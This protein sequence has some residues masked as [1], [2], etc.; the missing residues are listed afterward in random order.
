MTEQRAS[1]KTVATNRAL[2]I[3]GS[4]GI[5][6][7]LVALLEEE[8]WDIASPGSKDLNLIDETAIQNWCQNESG[9]FGLVIILAGKLAPDEWQYK[10][11]RDYLEAYALHAAGPVVLLA[12]LQKRRLIEWWTKVVL[13]SS[14]GAVNTGAVDLAYGCAKAALE[15]AHKAL[16][17]YASWRCYLVRLDLVD[18]RMLRQLPVDTL[19]GRLVMSPQEA[20]ELIL[21]E[22]S[23]L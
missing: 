7:T 10:G 23:I 16:S 5:G 14:V 9:A 4:G 6:T 20:A 2:V 21:K 19:H 18:T 11:M 1:Y 17:E 12:E 15:K 13:V 22:A 3:G 8:G